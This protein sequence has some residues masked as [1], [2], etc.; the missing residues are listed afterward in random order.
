LIDE[1]RT[2]KYKITPQDN[3]WKAFKTHDEMVQ[4]CRI[5]SKILKKMTEII[6]DC[7]IY[8]S[9]NCA[10]IFFKAE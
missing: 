3:E 1:S 7:I 6:I 10:L 4:A 2:F 5:P 8:G 9:I